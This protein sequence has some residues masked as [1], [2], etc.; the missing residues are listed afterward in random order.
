MSRERSAFF[1]AAALSTSNWKI[2]LLFCRKPRSSL[3]LFFQATNHTLDQ[4]RLVTRHR[5]NWENG[6]EA[7]PGCVWPPWALS[8]RGRKVCLVQQMCCR[9]DVN[10]DCWKLRVLQNQRAEFF[11]LT[12][13][14]LQPTRAPREMCICFPLASFTHFK[15]RSNY[16][17][18]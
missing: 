18:T 8:D 12:T 5:G 2:S 16:F 6:G 11:P 10:G 1:C 15:C 17:L 13:Q 4:V 7:C 14:A 3:L 9:P